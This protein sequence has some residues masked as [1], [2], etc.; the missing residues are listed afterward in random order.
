MAMAD[1]R[2]AGGVDRHQEAT[3]EFLHPHPPALQP[4]DP[5]RILKS[6]SAAGADP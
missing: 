6:K 2:G 3:D 5:V 1:F 4:F